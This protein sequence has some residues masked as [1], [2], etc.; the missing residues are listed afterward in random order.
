M[1]NN[2]RKVVVIGAGNVGIA[3]AY[4][5]AK[6]HK[7]SDLV[8]IDKSK[9]MGLTSAQCGENYRNWWP[10]LPLPCLSHGLAALER[11]FHRL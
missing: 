2:N 5:L 3:T 11:P 8:I 6:N 7:I 1:S 9:P 10:L 4:Y